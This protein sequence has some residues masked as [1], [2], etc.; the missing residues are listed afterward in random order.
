V[1]APFFTWLEVLFMTVNYRPDLRKKIEN[2][3][4]SSLQQTQLSL[5]PHD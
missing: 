4:S 3:V 5:K 1:L 2:E